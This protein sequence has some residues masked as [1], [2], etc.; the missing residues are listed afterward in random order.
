[1]VYQ[2]S[3][4][5]GIYGGD[6]QG[7][8]ITGVGQLSHQIFCQFDSGYQDATYQ[9]QL[10]LQRWDL[11]KWL[12]QENLGPASLELTIDGRGLSLEQMQNQFDLILT[13]AE[14][15]GYRYAPMRW[16]GSLD[17]QQLA[18]RGQMQDPG[19]TFRSEVAL[20]LRDSLPQWQLSLAL[21]TLALQALKIDSTLQGISTELALVGQGSDLDNLNLSLDLKD[22]WLAGS[23][24]TYREPSLAVRL[25]GKTQRQKLFTLSSQ[26]LSARL[27]GECTLA[28]LPLAVENYQRQLMG[29]QEDTL[30][31]PEAPVDLDFRVSISQIDRLAQLFVPELTD[32]D[33]L[34]AVGSWHTEEERLELSTF[35]P[36]LT[37]AGFSLDSLDLELL[38]KGETLSSKLAV[39]RLSSPDLTEDL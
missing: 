24:E 22:T 7:K 17:Q 2:A 8:L 27:T 26:F 32:L 1:L 23:G 33:T 28:D 19:L 25:Q 12:A 30:R 38:G 31:V 29:L 10:G 36:H 21:D 20:D 39:A 13:E 34:S 11:G 6:V 37:Y 5:G 15:N 9:G 3:S 18:A 14:V 35:L 4:R 16:S